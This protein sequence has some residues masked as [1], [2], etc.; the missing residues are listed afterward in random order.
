[1]F[2]KLIYPLF[3]V[4]GKNKALPVHSMPGVFKLSLDRIIK[5]L[6][7]L[8][9]HGL[10]YILLFGVPEI[11]HWHGNCAYQENNLVAQSVKSIKNSFPNLKVITDV[12]LC[13]Y[14]SHG[15]CGVIHKGKK[16]IDHKLTLEALSWMALSHARAGVDFVAPSA[17]VQRQVK[18]IRLALDQGG[19]RK[20][21]IMS[22][23]AKFASNFYG[24][25]REIADSAPKFGSRRE[26]QLD[27][28]DFK[29]ALDSVAR[30]IKEGGD[31]VMV[32]PSL[33]YLDIV[34]QVK[35][36]FKFPLAVYNVSG[37]YTMIKKGAALGFWEE[38]EIVSELFTSFKRAGAD[39][40]ISY[41]VK[42][43]L[44][45]RKNS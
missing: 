1:M 14:T 35:D 24:P 38:K 5:Q 22:Y 7:I 21:K 25:F 15:H 36:K 32:K 18:A 44:G 31:V 29:S 20:T 8:V 33:G 37:E 17:M 45:W 10:E 13:A 28:S 9:K 30:D 34:R 12:C 2:I 43:F 6:D 19:C 42:D 39:F 3:V 27:Y 11:K 23:S 41:H 26:Y 4:S 16:V 40:I